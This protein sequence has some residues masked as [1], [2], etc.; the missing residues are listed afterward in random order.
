MNAQQ[1]FI[2]SNY[3][4][5]NLCIYPTGNSFFFPPKYFATYLWNDF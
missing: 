1:M 2:E 3:S 5:H 4:L